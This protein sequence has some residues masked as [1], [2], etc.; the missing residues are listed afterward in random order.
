MLVTR[1]LGDC[2]SCKGKN[3]FGNV[4]VQGD[5]VLRG[6]MSCSYSKIIPLPEIRKKILYLDQ[7]FFS[8]AFRGGDQRFVDAVDQIRRISALQLLIVP[9]S[10]IH[11]DE[12]HQ[13]RGYDGKSREDLMQF[14]KATSRGFKYEPP[15]SVEETQ[16]I[17][18]FQ[19]FLAGNSPEFEM[20]ERHILRQNVHKWDGYFRIDVGRYMGDIDLIRDLK[21]QSVEGL[22]NLFDEW[23]KSENTFD[24]DVMLEFNASSKGYI[25]TYVQYASRIAVG[26]YN[27]LFDAPIRSQVVQS[28]LVC[29]PDEISPAQ[30]LKK[31][32]QFFLS[33]HFYNIPY[34]WVSSRIYAVLKHMVKNGAYRNADSTINKLRGFFYDVKHVALYAPYCDAFIM[35]QPMASIVS[36]SRI[37]LERKYGVRVFSLNNWNELF[38]W[39]N[40]IE[41]GM[42]EE[43]KLGIS[44]A[45][46]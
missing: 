22:V 19:S 16:I 5:H 23:R 36:D 15:D 38:V 44:A 29:F 45:Y 28:L 42:S 43:H 10:S 31:I 27:A 35:D 41:E 18:A 25:D 7:F 11:E 6:C 33:K 8:S 32:G 46:P 39:L 9:Y 24:Q 30:R 21:Q 14:I 1:I 12:T 40:E 34:Q 37:A 2:P 17:H 20:Q 4:S 3:K 26:D 13:W